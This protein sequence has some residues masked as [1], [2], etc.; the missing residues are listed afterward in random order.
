MSESCQVVPLCPGCGWI[1]ARVDRPGCGLGWPPKCGAN[2]GTRQST[3]WFKVEALQE[4]LVRARR[5]AERWLGAVKFA[6]AAL[7]PK[8]VSP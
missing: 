1:G 8:A 6:E 4:H 2:C 5:E 3:D 7:W